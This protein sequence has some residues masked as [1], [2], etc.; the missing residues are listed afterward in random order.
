MQ[1]GT[2]LNLRYV[3]VILVFFFMLSNFYWLDLHNKLMLH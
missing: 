1:I 3:V 2:Q